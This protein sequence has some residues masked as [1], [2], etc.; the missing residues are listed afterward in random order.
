MSTLELSPGTLPGYVEQQAPSYGIDPAAALAV[1]Q[2]EGLGGGIG[3]QGTSF[4][5]W[6]LHQGGAYPSSAPQG[7]SEAQAWAWSQAGVNYALEQI[8]SV[9]HGLTG[10]Q[11]VQAIVYRF[12][13]PK[14]PAQEAADAQLAYGTYA[15]GAAA[16][17]STTGTQQTTGFSGSATTMGYTA[18][19]PPPGWPPVGTPASKLSAAQVATIGSAVFTGQVSEAQVAAWYP[20][21]TGGSLH[22]PSWLNPGNDLSAIGQAITSGISSAGQTVASGVASGVTSALGFVG[23]WL[24]RGVKIIA[25][26]GLLIL[27]FV[28]IF[29]ALTGSTGVTALVPS[30]MKGAVS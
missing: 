29:K 27:A 10:S 7:E 14:N 12:E 20:G 6:Q 21:F 1:A 16:G 22:L 11:A 26:L 15:G 24:L 5:P 13:R 8:A 28:G 18:G 23:G 3:D 25:G 17:L 19:S 30:A 2:Q 9:A 4:G